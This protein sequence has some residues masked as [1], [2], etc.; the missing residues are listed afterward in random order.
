M[1]DI[2]V[3]GGGHAAA[4]FCASIAELKLPAKLALVSDE[5]HLPYQRPPLSKTYLKDP[6][7]QPAWLRGEAFYAQC[8]ARWQLGAR[9]TKIDRKA[10]RVALNSGGSLPYDYLVLATG[11]RPRQLPLLQ[12]VYDN[13]HTVRTL[14]DAVRLREQLGRSHHVVIVGGGFIGLE[15]AATAA[16]LGKQVSVLEAGHRLLSRSCSPQLSEYLLKKHRDSGVDI[17]LNATIERVQVEGSRVCGLQH[18]NTIIPADIVV[19]GIGAIPNDELA[20]EAGLDCDNGVIVDSFMTTSD[21]RILAIGDCAAFPSPALRRRIRLESVQNAN[22]QARCAAL[23]LAGVPEPYSAL[24]WFWSEQGSV[25]IQIAGVPDIHHEQV[26][27]GNPSADKFSILYFD[28]DH[29]TCVESVNS[30]ADHMAARKLLSVPCVMNSEAAADETVPL[31][32]FISA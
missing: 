27:R 18:G 6:Q 30:P 32:S 31:K 7:S 16:S 15:V 24:P 20:R 25:R 11:T 1:N 10:R 3:V 19:V 28:G 22:D 17:R 5:P 21:E 23:T 14:K 13:V 4:Q 8:G 2:V 12:G 26:V 9:V 29:L